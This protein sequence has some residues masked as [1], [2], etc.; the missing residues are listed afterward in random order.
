M[1]HD[2]LPEAQF[3][4]A[5]ILGFQSHQAMSDFFDNENLKAISQRLAQFSRAVHA[6]QLEKTLKFIHNGEQIPVHDVLE[7][8]Q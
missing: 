3:Q 7:N 8:K 4:A 2:N 5:L 1:A 6:Y